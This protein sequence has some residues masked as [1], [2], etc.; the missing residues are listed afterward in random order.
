M[1][2]TDNNAPGGRVP[3]ILFLNFTSNALVGVN[4]VMHTSRSNLNH[5]S[6][7]RF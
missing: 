6:E 7:T 4:T 2:H 5:C 3:L 1:F